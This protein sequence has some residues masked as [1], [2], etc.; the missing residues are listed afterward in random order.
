[1]MEGQELT[2][3]NGNVAA[4]LAREDNGLL[5]IEGSGTLTLSYSLDGEKWDNDSETHQIPEN[6][7]I[8]I[9]TTFI[10]GCYYKITQSG[11][12]ITRCRIKY[13]M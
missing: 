2:I 11:G 8:N 12:I 7:H 9:E 13:G 1:M 6:G 4:F 3:E 5:L 10:P